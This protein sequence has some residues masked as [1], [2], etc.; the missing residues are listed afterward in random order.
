MRE[1]ILKLR[2]QLIKELDELEDG[3]HVKLTNYSSDILELL[4][5]DQID[6]IS[7]MD[8]RNK[9]EDYEVDFQ[10]NPIEDNEKYRTERFCYNDHYY[11]D[12]HYYSRI[13][14]RTSSISDK[15]EPAKYKIFALP[16]RV[17]KKIDFSNI[18]FANF[19][20][21]YYDFSDLYGVQIN[22]QTVADRDFTKCNLM[23]VTFTSPFTY[24]II[25]G[26]KFKGSKGA[27][28]SP[29][30]LKDKNEG[31]GSWKHIIDMSNCDFADVSFN[32]PFY[33]SSYRDKDLTIDISGSSFAG[34]KGAVIYPDSVKNLYFVNL[35]D[36]IIKGKVS[37]KYKKNDI[38][39]AMFA[40]AMA[41]SKLGIKV[42]IIIDTNLYKDLDFGVF[43]GVKFIGDF[44]GCSIMRADFTGS[45]GAIIDL[46]KIDKECDYSKTNFTDAKVIG[47][48]GEV[49][50]VLEDGRLSKPL[51]DELDKLLHIEHESKLIAK[52]DEENA[53]KKTIEENRVKLKNTINEL[54]DLLKTSEILGLDSQK[55]Y[56]TIPIDKD[57]FLVQIDD[58][59]EI[60]RNI[61]DANLLRFFNLS[62]IDFTNVLVKGLDF[63]HSKARIIP[64][65]VYMKDISGCIFDGVNIKF[66]DE[67]DGVLMDGTNFDECD[68]N[69][70]ENNLS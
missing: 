42:P 2:E 37:T 15:G 18:S 30:N 57:L 13:I 9:Y 50:T 36:A 32:A 7:K 16:K 4:L 8:F 56:G 20:V 59:Y 35:K 40:G 55:L 1:K 67:F 5:F 19:V 69:P 12:I 51:E 70:K 49:M 28:I 54:L 29:L 25:N 44:S 38:A 68:F 24:C 62:M 33:R 48:H 61:I 6:I 14:T 63:R 66:F 60:N 17:L 31:D 11:C 39:G 3:V 64:K 43:D 22:P 47:Y 34:S 21:M 46:R 53:R 41:V 52:Q 27:V 58:H 10:N 65:N 23:G 26:A 45:T